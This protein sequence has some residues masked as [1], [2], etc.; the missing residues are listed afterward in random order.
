MESASALRVLLDEVLPVLT[1]AASYVCC[2]T[3][4]AQETHDTLTQHAPLQQSTAQPG[5]MDPSAAPSVSGSNYKIIVPSAIAHILPVESTLLLLGASARLV[6]HCVPL[7]V[8]SKDTYSTLSRRPHPASPTPPQDDLVTAL[9]ALL[10]LTCDLVNGGPWWQ[11]AKSNHPLAL[12]EALY[13]TSEVGVTLVP[14]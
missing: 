7:A 3:S 14:P 1:H 11:Q 2:V 13:D 4:S 6:R 12:I 10:A 9:D 8:V 5:D